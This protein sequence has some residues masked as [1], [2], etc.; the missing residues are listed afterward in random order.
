MQTPNR[1]YQIRLLH[2]NG[3]ESIHAWFTYEDAEKKV[4]QLMNEDLNISCYEILL[5]NKTVAQ[6][7]QAVSE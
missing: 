2:S 4:T 5:E 7:V 6:G 3:N 1:D